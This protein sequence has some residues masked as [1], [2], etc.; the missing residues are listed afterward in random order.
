MEN[1]ES[2]DQAKARQ[3][4]KE[5]HPLNKK[6]EEWATEQL[7]KM[8]FDSKTFFERLMAGVDMEIRF[9]KDG[10]IIVL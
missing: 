6:A 3:E 7:S 4:Y 9:D 5:N 2:F 8:E 1:W 10:K